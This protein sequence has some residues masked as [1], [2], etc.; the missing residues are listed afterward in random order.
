MMVISTESLDVSQPSDTVSWNVSVV[1]SVT[2]GAANVGDAVLLSDIVVV[3]PE[4]WFH[5][6]DM[7]WSSGSYDAVP[8]SVIVSKGCTV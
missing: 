6:Y 3:G 1:S 7:V 4:V 5:T 2:A 8:F